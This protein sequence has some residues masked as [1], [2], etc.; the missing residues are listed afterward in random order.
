MSKDFECCKNASCQ[1][2]VRCLRW[3]KYQEFLENKWKGIQGNPTIAV[4]NPETDTKCPDFINTKKQYDTWTAKDADGN[5]CLFVNKPMCAWVARDSDR[6][7]FLYTMRKPEL[8]IGDHWKAPY[9]IELDKDL[10][11]DVKRGAIEPKEVDIVLMIKLQD[12]E[13]KG[14]SAD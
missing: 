1:D 11:P 7:L 14:K 4:L 13:S 8:G 10:Y 9:P 5:L 12:N 6:R 2:K 3:Q